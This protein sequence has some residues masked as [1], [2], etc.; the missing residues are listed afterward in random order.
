MKKSSETFQFLNWWSDRLIDQCYY[1]FA[2]GMGVDQAWLNI[3]P[4]FFKEVCVANH[5][6]LNVAYWNLHE[7]K[8]SIHNEMVF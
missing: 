5:K 4:L 7:R 2:E 6:G 3:V 1:N 8:L